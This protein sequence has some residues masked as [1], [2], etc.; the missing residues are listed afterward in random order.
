LPTDSYAIRFTQTH[1]VSGDTVVGEWVTTI[2]RRMVSTLAAQ[3][4]EILAPYAPTRTEE[5]GVYAFTDPD[6]GRGLARL[7][8]FSR[9]DVAGIGDLVLMEEV[10]RVLGEPD[11]F[12]N[13]GHGILNAFFLRSNNPV[14]AIVL[15]LAAASVGVYTFGSGFRFESPVS[16]TCWIVG[17]LI[18]ILGAVFVAMSARR[19]RWWLRARKT[20]MRLAGRIPDHLKG[21]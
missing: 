13:T 1:D 2:E 8:N 9:D 3:T 12:R 19:M 7:E 15:G 20:A 21:L 18:A 14:T 6:R 10:T 16:V 11:P 5:P 17:G 4:L